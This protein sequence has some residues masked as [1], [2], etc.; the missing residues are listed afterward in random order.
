[1]RRE[2]YIVFTVRSGEAPGHVPAHLDWL[3]GAGRPANHF[4]GGP[5]DLALRHGDG[6]RAVLV[7]HARASLG[8]PA[9][10]HVGFDELEERLGMS[11]SYRVRLADP[12]CS[13][14]VVDAL[15]A[16]DRVEHAEV[17]RLASAPFAATMTAP[18]PEVD[19][20][21]ARE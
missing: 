18:A 7:F 8:T 13:D 20:E 1:M 16:L 15:P 3:L 6:Y 14:R 19:Q 4:D 9:E 2:G 10:H 21:L 5:I 11:R 12:E 17:Q